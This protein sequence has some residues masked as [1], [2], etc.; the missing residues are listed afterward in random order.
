RGRVPFLYYQ[1]LQTGQYRSE[2]YKWLSLFRGTER[3][4][5]DISQFL[6]HEYSIKRRGLI[7]ESEQV[8]SDLRYAA[9]RLWSSEH[10]Q[11]RRNNELIDE[12]AMR[13]LV[14]HDLETYLGVIALRQTEQVT[15]LGYRH[16]L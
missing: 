13:Q 11:R 10:A 3:P 12:A 7:E 1:Y 15:E 14:K 4:E 9:D 16:W 5:E 6:F 8:N 2:F